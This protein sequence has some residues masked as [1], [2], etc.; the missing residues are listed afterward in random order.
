MLDNPLFCGILLVT[1][2]LQALIVQFGSIAFRVAEGGLNA[3]DWGISLVLGA[4]SLPVQQII[5]FLYHMAK[6]YHV[7]KN[8]KRKQKAA[9]LISERI[10]GGDHAHAE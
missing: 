2:I 7:Y 10:N 8:K 3:K 1:A 4:L 5:N 9:R 6:T